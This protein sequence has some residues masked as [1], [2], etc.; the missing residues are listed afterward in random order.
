MS[1]LKL[2]ERACLEELFDMASGYVMDFSNRTFSEFFREAINIDI[3]AEKY[4]VNGE[5]KARRLRSF[6]E[7]EADAV[8]GKAVAERIEYWR[9]FK[10]SPT[11][12]QIELSKT[13]TRIAERLLGRPNLQKDSGKEFLE[14]EFGPISLRDIPSAAPLVTILE[15]RMTETLRC[16]AAD[17][18]LAVIFHCGSILEGLLLGVAV[19]SPRQFNQSSISPKDK[20]GDVK[21]LHQW[22]LSQLID[23]ACELGYLRLDVKKFSHALRDFRNYIHPYEQMSAKF[24]PDMHTAKICLQ[25]L[26][27]AT[28]SLSKKSM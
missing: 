23:V 14:K 25:V 4:S 9:Y 22:T 16:F 27:A 5:S 13:A 2:V 8:V 1:S 28:A 6:W 7:I 12:Q 20:T 10:Q 24:D 21:P 17:S 19:S 26:K 18:P 15:A 11:A 3:Y